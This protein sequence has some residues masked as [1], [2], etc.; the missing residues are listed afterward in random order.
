MIWFS[1]FAGRALGIAIL[2]FWLG[3]S[4]ALAVSCGDTIFVSTELDSNLIDCPGDGVIIGAD[5]I[6]LKLNGFIIDGDAAGTDV[7]VRVTNG[8]K[9]KVT[10]PGIV[11]EFHEGVLFDGGTKNEIRDVTAEGNLLRGIHAL[12]SS[13]NK[14]KDNKVY[15]SGFTGIQVSGGSRNKVE[16][17]DAHG[18][19]VGILLG[20]SHD[21]ASG[22]NSHS[23]ALIGISVDG[24]DNNIKNNRVSQQNTGIAINPGADR[25]TVVR[26]HIVANGGVGVF[27][28]SADDTEISANIIANSFSGGVRILSG[29]DT[30]VEQNTF[31]N[32]ADQIFDTGTA[33]VV[34]ENICHPQDFLPMCN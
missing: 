14:I 24:N 9:V 20:G 4:P 18:N 11:R 7:G 12:N 29:N 13:K 16:K 34:S 8:N 31:S 15:G 19:E 28:Q 10:G 23:N 5:N 25:N 26:N 32:N 33:T 17:N 3:A 30:L 27:V 22:N 21:T 1:R 2:F 6:E